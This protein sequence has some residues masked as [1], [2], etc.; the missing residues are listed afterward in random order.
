MAASSFISSISSVMQNNVIENVKSGE[1]F[2]LLLDGS[3]DV[4]ATE[5]EI[6][7]VRIIE[8]GKPLIVFLGLMSVKDRTAEGILQ[9]NW[10]HFFMVSSI[11]KPN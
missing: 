11:G 2:S 3:T 10:T 9:Q 1:F 7:Y 4:S 8:D 6:V 5:K